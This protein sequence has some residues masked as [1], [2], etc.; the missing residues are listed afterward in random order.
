MWQTMVSARPFSDW[1]AAFLQTNAASLDEAD[2]RHNS[3]VLFRSTAAHSAAGKTSAI[4]GSNVALNTRQL[5]IIAGAAVIVVAAAV[6][7]FVGRQE[8]V[9]LDQ[10]A[11][12]ST[13]V[14]SKTTPAEM[15]VAGP[16][17]EMALGDPKAPNIVIE[18]ASM[19]CPH[20]GR[21]HADVYPEFK[22]KY[23][24]TGKAYFIFREF[25]LDPLATSASMLARCATPDRYFPIVD[26]LF[27][28]QNNWAFIQNP[29]PALQAVVKQAGI[30]Q[31][32]FQAC[33]TNQSILDGVNAVKKRAGD[34][35]GVNST[36]TFFF[37]GEKHAG[38]ISLAEIDKI[39]GG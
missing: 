25:P 30:T 8:H 28:Q 26:L 33:L 29:V 4:Q 37:N 5:L 24:D 21:F 32:S 14:A 20:C 13:P 23:V 31:D 38:E 16:L 12:S 35:F 1:A 9:V 6:F 39:L 7:F 19:T 17:G 11:A 18:Y 10:P 3:S 36:P 15:L 2:K 22:K 34:Q 27:D